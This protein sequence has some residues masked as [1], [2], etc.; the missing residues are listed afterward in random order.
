M[1]HTYKT[2]GTCATQIDFELDGNIVKNVVFH[3]GCDGNS[4]GVSILVEGMTVEEVIKKLR[5]ITCGRKN[6]SCPD[7][8]SIA[9]EEAYQMDYLKDRIYDTLM[10]MSSNEN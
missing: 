9:V 4:K 6:T 7:Q 10:G 2:Q 3:R 1:V 8:L 5:G